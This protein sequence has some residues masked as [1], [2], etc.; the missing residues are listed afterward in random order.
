MSIEENIKKID[1]S[2]A[3]AISAAKVKLVAVS[4]YATD[5]Q[6]IAAYD[7]G[8]RIFGENYVIPALKKIERLKTYFA[9]PVE[10]HLTGPIQKNKINKVV[11][12]FDLIHSVGSLEIAKA[13]NNRAQQLNYQQRV[14]LQLNYTGDKNGFGPENFEKIFPELEKLEYIII[15]GLMVMGPHEVSQKSETIF[16]DLR[17]KLRILLSRHPSRKF[18]L[19]M[20]M[21]NDYG[22][23]VDCGSTMIRIGRAIFQADG[24]HER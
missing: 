1:L 3:G 9:E 4:K 16:N 23:A 5:E 17:L 6:I 12:N 2:L 21:S 10:W 8:L 7:A 11:A 24:K 15:E 14:L 22:L 19:S 18:E 13:I 20:G